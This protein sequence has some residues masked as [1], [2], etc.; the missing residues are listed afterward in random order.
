VVSAGVLTTSDPPQRDNGK[1]EDTTPPQRDNGKEEDTTPPQRGNGKGD[2]NARDVHDN[3]ASENGADASSVLAEE[4]QAERDALS[5]NTVGLGLAFTPSF[6]WHCASRACTRACARV[7]M[8]ARA[9]VHACMQPP[10]PPPPLPLCVHACK[11]AATRGCPAVKCQV[12]SARTQRPRRLSRCWHCA[13]HLR[14]R[15]RV[16]GIHNVH[17]SCDEGRG[18]RG[19]GGGV[20]RACTCTCTCA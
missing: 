9:R 10:S 4:A 8:D 19:R 12:T 1:E 2:D 3:G 6:L 18:W 20:A 17:V 16:Q 11:H 5:H 7:S 13:L 14:A 15:T